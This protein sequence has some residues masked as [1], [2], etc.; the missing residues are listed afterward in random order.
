M[1]RRTFFPKLD[2]IDVKVKPNSKEVDTDET[3]Q[4]LQDTVA[5]LIAELTGKPFQ[6]ETS[7]A[8]DG[9]F[10]VQISRSKSVEIPSYIMSVDVGVFRWIYD[11]LYFVL[12]NNN[13]FHGIGKSVGTFD[14]PTLEV[15]NWTSLD[16]AMSNSASEVFFD[17][18]RMDLHNFLYNV[19]LSFILRH[20]IRHIANGHVGYLLNRS[21]PLFFENS[22]NGLSFIDSQTLEM[23]VDSCVFAGFL[24][25]FIN[26]E[27][28]S[29]MMPE[30][31]RD[32]R[33][34]M[35]TCL[36]CIQFLFYCLPSRKVKSKEHASN[37]SHPN[38]FMRYFFCF[39]TGVSL[40][41]EKYPHLL[42]EF[43]EL[44]RDNFTVFLDNLSE[45]GCVDINRIIED[46]SWTLSE[47]GMEY[48][49]QIWKNWDNIAPKLE[50]FAYLKL[51][52]FR[53]DSLNDQ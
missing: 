35:M 28:H 29:A 2:L 21:V 16:L 33:G 8:S 1:L 36:F 12:S 7:V 15:P 20:E 51:A 4:L 18:E 27:N 40:L 31:L 32:S 25:G 24:E 14:I 17:L 13:V 53:T 23:D 3:A 19:C 45:M 48:S 30:V 38:S 49:N 47:E 50:E 39:T 41:E 43:T 10:S 44:A 9:F 5:H 11:S 6:L 52:P 37:G 42:N 22:S 46:Q 26:D 34:K